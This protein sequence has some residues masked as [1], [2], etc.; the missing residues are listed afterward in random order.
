MPL[1]SKGFTGWFSKDVQSKHPPGRITILRLL[2]L[3]NKSLQNIS[4]AL[5][6]AP[7]L[8]DLSSAHHS[9]CHLSETT[10]TITAPF[11]AGIH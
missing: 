2:Q 8:I 4:S 1:V 3:P 11:V 9:R 5:P 10:R 6:R 7:T